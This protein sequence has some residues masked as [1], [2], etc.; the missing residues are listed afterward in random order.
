MLLVL[1]IVF[2]ISVSVSHV[3]G[4][5]VTGQDDLD[6][7]GI[8]IQNDDGSLGGSRMTESEM[9]NKL[10]EYNTEISTLCN[11]LKKA[12]WNVATDVGNTQ[13]E[14]EKVGFLFGFS[15]FFFFFFLF[16]IVMVQQS[17]HDIFYFKS[18]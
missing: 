7:F 12:I 11:G 3:F 10:V 8:S 6:P 1:W 2:S 4:Q 17:F 14:G 15:T 5:N 13:K 18:N 16:L 9:E